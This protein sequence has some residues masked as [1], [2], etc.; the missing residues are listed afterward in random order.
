MKTL[1][2]QLQEIMDRAIEEG[3]PE[4]AVW[5]KEQM[6]DNP[7][8]DISEEFWDTLKRP[9]VEKSCHTCRWDFQL[10]SIDTPNGGKGDI[11][12][13]CKRSPEESDS[14]DRWEWDRET[15]E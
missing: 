5:I 14:P 12:D 7:Q 10:F 11:C 9:F 3:L 1:Y 4:A 13:D 8:K 2:E 6:P 15:Y